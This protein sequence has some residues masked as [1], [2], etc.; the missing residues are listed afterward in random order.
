MTLTGCS[1]VTLAPGQSCHLIHSFTPTAGGV[2]TGASVFTLNG[3]Q[4]SVQLRGTGESAAT[5]SVLFLR[6]VGQTDFSAIA[7]STVPI[8]FALVQQD[9]TR[10]S[11]DDAVALATACG[12]TVTFSGA[13]GVRCATYDAKEDHFHVNLRLDRSLAP[14]AWNVVVSVV[15]GGAT[16]GTGSTGIRV[17]SPGS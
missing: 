12:V 11:D 13:A 1:E 14:G 7:G 16:V 17:R 4:Y 10:L 5:V 3:Q 8:K 9:G 6:P 15:S 2:A